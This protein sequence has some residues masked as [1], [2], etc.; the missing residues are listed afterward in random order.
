VTEEPIRWTVGSF[1]SMMAGKMHA[2]IASV[3]SA[4][5][6][7]CIVLATSSTAFGDTCT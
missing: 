2:L 3:G 4:T 6:L 5:N 1:F 7:L